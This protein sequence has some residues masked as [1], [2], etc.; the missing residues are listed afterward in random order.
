MAGKLLAWIVLE[1]IVSTENFCYKHVGLFS[2]NTTAVL[3]TH[4]GAAKKSAAAGRLFRV[5]DLLERVERA[6]PLVAVH[7][8][9][10]LNLL[11]DIP[12][13]YLGYSKQWHCTN[14]SEF[15]SL[16]KSKFPLPYQCSYQGFRLSF[17]L[18]TKV[19]SEFGKKAYLIG[20]WKRLQI[21]G[22]SFGGSGVPIA[23]SLEMTC[24]WNKSMSK[25]NQGLQQD[26]Q[27]A[28]EKLAMAVDTYTSWNSTCS[29]RRC[30]REGF[31]GHR[32]TTP[33][34]TWVIA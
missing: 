17:A 15:L 6:L 5:L 10:Y 29:T 26:S 20:E 27:A 24:T 18:S 34:P 11:G 4:R 1:G 31:P 2:D 30:Q 9:G 14:D 28:C 13:S 23:N 33:P 21:I 22:K 8:S 3:S 16:I 19:I 32:A 25:P 12:F 7:V